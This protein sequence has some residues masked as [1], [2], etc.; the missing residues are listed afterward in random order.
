MYIGTGSSVRCL[1]PFK[2]CDILHWIAELTVVHTQKYQCVDRQDFA[3]GCLG[4]L[5]NVLFRDRF[6]FPQKMSAIPFQV[7]MR[8]QAGCLRE[9]A[10]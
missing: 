9:A 6:A 3:G 1:V 10:S 2:K 5:M 7:L 4:I 8:L